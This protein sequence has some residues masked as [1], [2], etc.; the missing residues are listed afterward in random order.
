M[1]KLEMTA[2]ERVKID[3]LVD[4]VLSEGPW[5][6]LAFTVQASTM[7]ELLPLRLRQFLRR[8]EATETDVIILSGLPVSPD[9]APTP[10]GWELAQKTG[11]GCRE[12]VVLMLCSAILG[13]PFCWSDQQDGRMV[14][15]ICP[16]PG[17]ETSQTS[18]SSEAN[19]SLH[20]EDAFHPCRG[21]YVSLFCLRNPDNVGTTF[22]R[23]QQLDIPA[24]LKELLSQ[25]RFQHHPDQSHVC[26]NGLRSVEPEIESI[27]FGPPESQYVRIDF[28]DTAPVDPDDVAAKLAIDA[29]Y[30]R[31]TGALDRLVLRPGDAVF[32]DNYRVVH[33]REPFVPRYDGADRWLKRVNLIRDIR[34]IYMASKQ[35]SRVVS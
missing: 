3:R 28:D 35:R 11:A 29:I 26:T 27:L 22:V 12:E 16:A 8:C 32:L 7:A 25:K 15:D 17:M 20:T 30:E 31:M 19:L 6:P 5:D 34:R 9:L 33:G 10:T 1:E 21:D 23:A 14:H 4:E 2:E 24:E 13:E 18:G